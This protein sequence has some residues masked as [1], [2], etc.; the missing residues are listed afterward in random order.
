ML[1]EKTDGGKEDGESR[2]GRAQEALEKWCRDSKEW[3]KTDAEK[4]GFSEV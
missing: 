4:T 3:F 2:D 1:S